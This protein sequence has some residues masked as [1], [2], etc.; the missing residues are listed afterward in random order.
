MTEEWHSVI[1]SVDEQFTEEALKQND[2]KKVPLRSNPG[3]PIIGEATLSYNSETKALMADFQV[4]DPEMAALL[5][6]PDPSI[7]FKKES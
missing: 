4:D 6:G 5:R 2:G 1:Q 7:I 3:G